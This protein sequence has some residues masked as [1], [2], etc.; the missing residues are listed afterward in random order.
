M[1]SKQQTHSNNPPPPVCKR[2]GK[3]ATTIDFRD[4]GGCLSRVL[5]CNECFELTERDYYKTTNNE[6]HVKSIRREN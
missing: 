6:R 1:Q 5:S 4:N 2:C 3:P